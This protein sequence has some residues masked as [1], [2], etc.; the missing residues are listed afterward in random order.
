MKRMHRMAAVLLGSATALALAAG[1]AGAIT[2]G[3]LERSLGVFSRLAG[4]RAGEAR[5]SQ[6]PR[7]DADRR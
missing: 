6:L 5:P 3:E 4:S 7:P 1:P 2:G